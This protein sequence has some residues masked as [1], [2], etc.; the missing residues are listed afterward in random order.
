MSLSHVL[1]SI[2]AAEEV[3]PLPKMTEHK[4]GSEKG[5]KVRISLHNPVV[6]LQ[7]APWPSRFGVADAGTLVG[8]WECHINDWMRE[9]VQIG[10]QPWYTRVELGSF[11]R[12]VKEHMKSRDALP[13]YVYLDAADHVVRASTSEKMRGDAASVP[14]RADSAT[15]NGVIIHAMSRSSA[16]APRSGANTGSAPRASDDSGPRRGNADSPA[17]ARRKGS[18][19]SCNNFNSGTG[20][21]GKA[22]P[23]S[24]CTL[25]GRYQHVC[26]RCKSDKHSAV[27][28]V[29]NP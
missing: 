12:D 8:D 24:Q 26:A 9:G 18:K 11:M 29:A 3:T 17:A 10:I 14:L 2:S 25:R 20:E 15:F 22:A 28:C 6:A 19:N 7:T 23:G 13:F 27:A 4:L 16:P 21:C 1:G 5:T